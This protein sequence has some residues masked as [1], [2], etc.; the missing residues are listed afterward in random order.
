MGTRPYSQEDPLAL[1]LCSGLGAATS[2]VDLCL[3]TEGD[4][5]A[6]A[7]REDAVR[8]LKAVGNF[9]RRQRTQV[10]RRAGGRL[11]GRASVS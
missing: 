1:F 3:V 6:D 11:L 8:Q 5:Q 10:M 9:L 2:D 7:F 4:D